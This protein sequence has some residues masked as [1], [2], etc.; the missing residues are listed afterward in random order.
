MPKTYD[1]ADV[2]DAS[3]SEEYSH[4]TPEDAIADVVRSHYDDGDESIEEVIGNLC[5]LT[6]A[7]LERDTINPTWTRRVAERLTSNVADEWCD[8]YG[9]PDGMDG[10]DLVT[11]EHDIKAAL[12]AFVRDTPVWACSACGKRT[13]SFEEVIAMMKE[14]APEW[15]DDAN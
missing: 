8:E 13:Y 10:S 1:T 11:I 5:P 14:Y 12:D 6:V 7:G 3:D 4:T 2:Y 15:F 9:N